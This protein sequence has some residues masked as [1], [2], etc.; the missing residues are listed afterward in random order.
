MGWEV[1]EHG[2]IL[3]CFSEGI[4]N[5]AEA[6]PLYLALKDKYEV[7]V[8]YVNQYPT[9]SIEKASFV[10]CMRLWNLRFKNWTE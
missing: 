4:G 10:P 3:F 2:M 6:I 5:C 7:D 9:D 8:A 1:Q